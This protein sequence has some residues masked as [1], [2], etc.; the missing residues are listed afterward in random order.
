MTSLSS[1]ISTGLDVEGNKVLRSYYYR[2]NRLRL[3]PLFYQIVS[4]DKKI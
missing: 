1:T 3:L 4:F 2:V